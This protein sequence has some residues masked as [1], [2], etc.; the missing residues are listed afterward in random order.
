MGE[1]EEEEEEEVMMVELKVKIVNGPFCHQ[2]EGVMRMVDDDE[3]KGKE[4][5]WAGGASMTYIVS[6]SR[7]SSPLSPTR[8][9]PTD[10]PRL[11][12]L[13]AVLVL[14]SQK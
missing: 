3:A 8:L 14:I 11:S 12:S 1:E 4:E 7:Q 5:M 9:S 6:Q 2:K 13:S 10:S